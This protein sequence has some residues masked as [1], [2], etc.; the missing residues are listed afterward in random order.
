M[1]SHAARDRA[2]GGTRR[3]G[4]SDGPPDGFGESVRVIVIV[5]GPSSAT[6]LLASAGPKR[7]P[8]KALQTPS[9]AQE[10]HEGAAGAE[11]G[12]LHTYKA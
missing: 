3:P 11:G 2:R 7:R 9:K 10:A 8:P 5:T 1:G 4:G 12:R 6:R